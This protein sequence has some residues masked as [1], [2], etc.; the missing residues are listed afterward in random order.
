LFFDDRRN[1]MRKKHL[2]GAVVFGLALG[3]LSLLVSSAAY[4][5]PGPTA[6][7]G[8]AALDAAAKANKYLFIFFFNGRDQQ[9]DAMHGVFQTALA[10]MSDRAEAI[11]I[12][13]GDPAEKPLVDK[14]GVRGAP[15]PLVLAIAP[16]GA[17]TRAF[18]KQFDEAQLQQAFVTPCQAKCMRAIQDRHSILLCVQNGQTQLNQEAMQGVQAFKADP[19]YDRGTDIV[20]LNPADKAEVT[21]LNALKVDPQT[22][23]ATTVLIMPPGAPVA[24]FVGAVTK[25]EI[26]ASAKAAQSTCGP[27]CSCHH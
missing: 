2:S 26:E 9:T 17:A 15:M 19:Q 24:R 23:T 1:V 8:T 27:G 16:T 20:T 13:A 10:K 7:K 4:C 11:A 5:E 14:F 22:P 12:Q 25:T 3:W 18:P 6:S 21:F